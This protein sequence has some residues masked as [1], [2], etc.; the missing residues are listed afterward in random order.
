MPELFEI[1][2]AYR[3]DVIWS[4]GDWDARDTYWNSTEFLAWLYNDRSLNMKSVSHRQRL[5]DNLFSI[6]A[7]V[8]IVFLIQKSHG[9]RLVLADKVVWWSASKLLVVS[10]PFL[11]GE[12]LWMMGLIEK[13]LSK[14]F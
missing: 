13:N 6:K 11:H 5:C 1:V 9:R 7:I 8:H 10:A 2:N 12:T 3:P 4:D 14:N